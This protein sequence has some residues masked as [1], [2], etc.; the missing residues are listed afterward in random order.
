M[1]NSIKQDVENT[2]FSYGMRIRPY[3]IA[4]QPDGVV[5]FTAFE[6]IST[7][8]LEEWKEPD[9]RFGIIAYANPLSNEDISHYTLTDLNALSDNQKWDSFAEF[10]KDMAEYKI[11][12]DEFIADFIKPNGDMV[13]HNPL[14]K[15]KPTVL[16]SL[17]SK[18]NYK[19]NLKGL[20]E[21]YSKMLESV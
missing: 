2:T 14:H 13:E 20:A 4:C 18:N 6:D 21:Y 10:A 3:G 19:G 17:L 7:A 8:M 16:F 1:T 9:F 12:F 5:K 11:P 15:E